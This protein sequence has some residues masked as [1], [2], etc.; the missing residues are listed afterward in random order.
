MLTISTRFHCWDNEIYFILNII[1]NFMITHSMWYVCLFPLEGIYIKYIKFLQVS[2]KQ[3]DRK[4]MLL[5]KNKLSLTY[6]ICLIIIFA[7]TLISHTCNI[8]FHTCSGLMLSF[9]CIQLVCPVFY[10]WWVFFTFLFFLVLCLQFCASS[11]PDLV[12]PLQSLTGWQRGAI[13]QPSFLKTC[14]TPWNGSFSSLGM[15]IK[16]KNHYV[17]LLLS[18]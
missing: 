14:M 11:F 7:L 4:E 9:H 16:Q 17:K 2:W 5:V 1:I 13:Q 3:L 18:N 15:H 12:F 8:L 6:C 10:F